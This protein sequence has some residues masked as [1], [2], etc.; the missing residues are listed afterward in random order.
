MLARRALDALRADDTESA[1]STAARIAPDQ[2]N[3]TATIANSTLKARA[4]P[5]A[6]RHG[7]TARRHAECL[8][9][10]VTPLLDLDLDS[11]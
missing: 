8:V 5:A 2:R 9:A 4:D 6:R 10:R 11:T 7:S 1:E 3:A